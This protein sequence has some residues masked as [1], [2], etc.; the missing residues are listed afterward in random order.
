M[1]HTSVAT[2]RIVALEHGAFGGL[3]LQLD[4]QDSQHPDLPCLGCLVETIW[5]LLWGEVPALLATD[6]ESKI[7]LVLYARRE[8]LVDT[9]T[10]AERAN[11]R[12][13]LPHQP[14]GECT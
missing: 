8:H 14:Q 6:D 4:Y 10:V 1:T 12:L 13:H 9:K 2:A 11:S 7:A 5:S 3:K